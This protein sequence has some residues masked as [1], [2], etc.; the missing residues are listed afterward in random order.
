MFLPKI[1]CLGRTSVALVQKLPLVHIDD[2]MEL[3][4][5]LANPKTNVVH[6]T[7]AKSTRMINT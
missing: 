5:N 4:K 3:A 7:V 6:H 1:N 2:L